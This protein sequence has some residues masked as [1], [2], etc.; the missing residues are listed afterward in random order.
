MRKISLMR[1]YDKYAIRSQSIMLRFAATLPVSDDEAAV[2]EPVQRDGQAFLLIRLQHLW[3]EFCREL[4]VHSAVGGCPTRSG[5]VL[6]AAPDVERVS[7]IPTIISRHT[8]QQFF[9]PR[10]QWEDPNFAIR[11][12]TFLKVAN[13]NQIS[14]GL[15]SV[16]TILQEIKCVR[17]FVVHPNKDTRNKYVQATRSLGFRGL[18][19]VQL[20]NQSMR[21]GITVFDTWVSNLDTAAWN[22]VA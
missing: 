12:A 17:N 14:L 10:T 16:T 2:W 4:V 21:G 15:G 11:H 6:T 5:L 3:G 9:G 20:M 18:S 13:L 1:L 19:P 8:K 7:D 22:S